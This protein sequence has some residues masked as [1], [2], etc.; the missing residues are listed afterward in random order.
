MSKFNSGHAV[1]R[2]SR[3]P[4]KTVSS[5]PDT[6]THE[7]A[8]AFTRN[9]RSELFLL[10][11]S[12]FV[13]ESS[14]YEVAEDRDNRF[15]KLCREV[16]AE[17][18]LWFASF[19]RWLRSEGNMRSASLVAAAEGVHA[20]LAAKTVDEVRNRRI[21]SSVLQ[22]ADEPGELVAYWEQAF[23]EAH[24][25]DDGRRKAKLAMSV[26][27]GVAD[28]I[29]LYRPTDVLTQVYD[30][31]SALK[32]DT[33][34][35]GKRFADVVEL[36]HPEG[37]SAQ[38]GQYYTWLL[39][40]RHGRDDGDYPLL[41]MV[42]ARKQLEAVAQGD[43]R[44]LLTDGDAKSLMKSAGVTWEWM[45][46]WLGSELDATFWESMIPNM[47]YMALIRNLRN[48]DEKKVSRK[49]ANQVADRLA[50]PAQV[51][52]SRQL[53]FRFLSAYL[54]VGSDRWREP[55]SEALTHSVANVP[56]LP[57][58]SLILIDT[59]GS[60]QGVMGGN[61]R[62]PRR[63][64][65]RSVSPR[66]VQAAALFGV[67][68]AVKNA[69]RADLRI[70]ADRVSSPMPVHAGDSVLHMTE[71]INGKIGSV[72]HGTEIEGSIRDAWDGHDRVLVFTDEQTFGECRGYGYGGHQGVTSAVPKHIPMY[73]WNLQGYEAAM[74]ASESNRHQLGSLTDHAFVMISRI[75]QGL[76]AEW[77]WESGT[78][79]G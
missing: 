14:F 58:R 19:V 11:V 28:A 62:S 23:G 25:T 71:H 3:S 33:D 17:D 65:S 40:R 76:R 21:I 10:G 13:G 48:F 67:A 56:E 44:A 54:N 24:P 8:P 29:E 74:M 16:A 43:R 32:Y 63:G 64:S 12:N 31:Y 39:D 79:R 61:E 73:S 46:S 68:V 34:S 38:R 49:V 77:P 78:S 45:A 7:G 2:S 51:A 5:T 9:A 20:R 57:G 30:E 69:G 22:R 42:A 70:F 27:R 26:K 60:M 75:E 47:G 41:E 52:K 50:D 1:T 37:Y 4:L 15:S 66:M 18:G 6:V 55:L 36:T 53:P 72:G 59:S 35:K